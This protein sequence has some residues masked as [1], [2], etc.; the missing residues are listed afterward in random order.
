VIFLSGIERRAPARPAGQFPWSLPVLRDLDA[1]AFSAPVTFLVGE[2]GSGKSSLLEGLAAGMGAVAVGSRDLDRDDSLHGVREFARAFRF[3]R[4]RHPRVKLFLRAEDVFGFTRRVAGEM[5]GLRV[6]EQDFRA[7]LPDGSSGQIRVTGLMAGQRR[8]LAARYGEEPLA[9]SHGET[10]LAI[11]QARLAPGGLYFLDEPETPLSPSRVLSLLAL[12]KDRV[13]HDCQ[14]I[15]ATHSPLLMALPGAEILLLEDG[16]IAPA[17]Y[18]ELEHV[19]LTRDFLAN[20]DRF[21]RHL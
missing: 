9:R 6:L 3:Q 17:A 12:L 4:R 20:P 11:L 1:L 18:D 21:L 2:N 16:S 15:I 8:A 5:S 10:F 19:R 13:Q 7:R 14:F